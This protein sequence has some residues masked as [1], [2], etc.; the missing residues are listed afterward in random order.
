MSVWLSSELAHIHQR[1]AQG[2]G[3]GGRGLEGHL[4]IADSWTP[5]RPLLPPPGA[6]GSVIKS[7]LSGRAHQLPGDLRGR[8]TFSNTMSVVAFAPSSPLED[9]ANSREEEVL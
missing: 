5:P 8:F 4:V 6:G 2:R 7:R 1:R 3:C 9:G